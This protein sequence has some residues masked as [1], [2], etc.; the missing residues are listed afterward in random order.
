MRLI[1][2]AFLVV[3]AFVVGAVI[4]I[5]LPRN[6]AASTLFHLFLPASFATFVGIAVIQRRRFSPAAVFVSAVGVVVLV[7]ALGVFTEVIQ[8]WLPYRS[9]TFIDIYINLVGAVLGGA[10]TT[11]FG[12]FSRM[13]EAKQP[14]NF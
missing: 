4:P 10:T 14:A 7:V 11:V 6:D 9:A 3:A 1:L 2:A 12:F 5:P 13:R 8:L